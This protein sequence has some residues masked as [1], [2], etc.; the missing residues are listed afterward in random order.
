MKEFVINKNDSGQR[1]DKFISKSVPKLPKSLMYK[2]IRIKRIKVNGK[3]C[4]REYMLVEGDRICMY[5]NDEFFEEDSSSRIIKTDILPEIIY[6]DDNILV[7]YKNP[8]MDVHPG[9]ERSGETLLDVITY[10]LF[11]KGEYDPKKESS[12]APALCNRIDRNTSGLVIAAKNAAALREINEK[13][14]SGEIKKEYL[15]VCCGVPNE[16]KL[17]MTAYHKK[18]ANRNK[19]E[20]RKYAKEGFKEIATEY[21]VLESKNG[22]SLL[23]VNLITGRTH[24]IRA[25]L[26]YVGLPLLGDGKYGD[27]ATNKRMR[28]FRQ[29]LCAYEIVYDF[30]SQGLLSNLSRK[31]ITARKCDFDI[32]MFD[33]ELHKI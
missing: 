1:L 33:E 29:Q 16:K 20:I 3:R 2:Y 28:V 30:E 13:I 9:A 23:R 17:R 7:V 6:E 22:L 26:S 8:G 12:F 32:D 10:Y 11:K 4:E 19:V 5:V 21:E 25:H 24:Q 27:I 31:K 15:C 18:D 14:R